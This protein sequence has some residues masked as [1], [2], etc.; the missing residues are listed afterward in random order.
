M[1]EA[2]V[3]LEKILVDSFVVIGLGFPITILL[4]KKG[5]FYF[6]RLLIT[7][8]IL[9]ASL[10]YLI[11]M[12]GTLI[13]S[14]NIIYFWI[15]NLLVFFVPSIYLIKV[16]RQWILSLRSNLRSLGSKLSNSLSPLE[17]ILL[18]IVILLLAITFVVALGSTPVFDDPLTEWLFMG[19]QI[20]MTGKIP[21]FFGNAPD[22]SWSGNYPPLNAF[23]SASI[24]FLS[25]TQDPF[26]YSLI[27]WLY[28]MLSLAAGYLLVIKLC[29]NRVAALFAVLITL[30]STTFSLQ[31]L[32]YGYADLPL[33]FFVVASLFMMFSDNNSAIVIFLSLLSLSDALLAK[34]SALIIFIPTIMLLLYLKK[35]LIFRNQHHKVSMLRL[36]AVLS[37][38]ALGFSWYLRNYI[39]VNDPVYPYLS[40]L[41]N[42][43]GITPSM[44]SINPE[45]Q[46]NFFNMFLDKTFTSLMNEANQ[47]PFIAFG[48]IGAIYL[49]LK[50]E[51]KRIKA[52]SF[53]ALIAF[54]LMAGYILVIGGFERYLILMVPPMAVLGGLLFNG[55]RVYLS[56]ALIPH[57]SP[58]SVSRYVGF[59]LIASLLVISTST[60]DLISYVQNPPELSPMD[61][62]AW[63]FINHLPP[64]IVAT[65]DLRRFYIDQ[66]IL[67]LDNIPGLFSSPTDQQTWLI[68]KNSEVNYVYL[69]S[70]FYGTS[71][72]YANL[73]QTF[74][75]SSY[76]TLLY[77][78]SEGSYNISVYGVN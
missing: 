7:S 21:V 28:G 77:Y 62:Q 74:T 8:A 65:N 53:W 49:I 48:F 68:L 23:Q 42:A 11:F 13:T 40:T 26:L 37:I 46:S 45:I 39:V 52:L 78:S 32:G 56:S 29:A 24:F 1:F 67:Q 72:S 59:G 66:G 4:T 54:F 50:K 25:N 41:F 12:L 75:N 36:V 30:F 61:G 10:Y 35:D 14:L 71:A 6:P 51:D 64:G 17:V 31:M 38:I 3:Y 22:I 33:T 44:I 47:W 15:I 63:T 19:K 57:A 69:N 60:I 9:S 16:K 70:R 2:I 5:P 20:F 27:P 58:S 76:L 34:Y 43:R 73:L 55:L 18:S